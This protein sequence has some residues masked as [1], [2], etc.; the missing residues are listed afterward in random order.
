MAA[1]QMALC[2]KARVKK[3][4]MMM[5]IGPRSVL[6]YMLFFKKKPFIILFYHGVQPTYPYNPFNI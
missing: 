3:P 2:R 4:N 1:R 5:M 6:P